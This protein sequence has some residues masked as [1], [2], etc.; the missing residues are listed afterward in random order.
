MLT[1]SNS[2]WVLPRQQGAAWHC[3][4]VQFG[5]G[6]TL[7]PLG[8]S[9]V[10]FPA[11]AIWAGRQGEPP[12]SDDD[13]EVVVVL[14]EELLLARPRLLCLSLPLWWW[15]RRA[16][17]RGAVELSD[18]VD[19]LSGELSLELAHTLRDNYAGAWYCI[20]VWPYDCC[21]CDAHMIVVSKD[22]LGTRRLW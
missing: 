4:F 14:L 18:A 21:A 20:S 22:W 16:R 15:R 10:L 6:L 2:G 1:S 8:F 3:E 12:A 13:D 9:P 11:F 17:C 19:S 7:K 5:F